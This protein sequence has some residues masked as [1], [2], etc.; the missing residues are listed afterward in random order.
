MKYPWTL[1]SLAAVTVATLGFI[2]TAVGDDDDEHE[3][4]E[5]ERSSSWWGMKRG[6]ASVMNEDYKAECGSCHTAYPA[7]LLPVRSWDKLMAN[8]DNHFGDNAELMPDQ[9]KVVRQ[10]LVENAADAAGYRTSAKILRTIVPDEAPLR[11]TKTRYFVAK[12]DEVPTRLVEKNPDVGSF[13]N[14]SACHKD[15]EKG[16]FNEHDVRIP[17][18]GR[19]DD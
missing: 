2:G 10:Y 13:S 3:R 16:Y 6:V 9:H 8:L 4:Y 5:H 14:C 19:F 7:G 1:I 17:G 11:I 15:A 18:Y 12:H